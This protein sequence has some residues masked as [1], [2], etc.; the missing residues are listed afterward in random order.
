MNLKAYIV[1]MSSNVD[2]RV[3]PDEVDKVFKAMAT[4]NFVKVRQGGINPSFLIAIVEDKKRIE[5][6]LEKIKNVETHNRY[7]GSKD[8]SWVYNGM[9]SLRDIFADNE[10]YNEFQLPEPDKNE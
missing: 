9:Q 7:L 6:E 5:A 4:N 8:K 3:D 2:V 10:K 1:K